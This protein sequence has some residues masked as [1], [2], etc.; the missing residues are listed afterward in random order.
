MS[1]TAK[2]VLGLQSITMQHLQDIIDNEFSKFDHGLC[3]TDIN[4]KDKQ[5]YRSCEKIAS[6]DVLS[7]LKQNNDMQATYVYLRLLKQIISAY[8]GKTTRIT[9]RL[10]SA[11]IIVFTC[12]LWRAWIKYKTFVSSNHNK[13]TNKKQ[14]N[15]D[16]YF[17][18]TPVYYSIEINAHNLLYLILLVKQQQLP[19]HVLNIYLFSSQACESTFRDT[20]S[21]SGTYS[22]IVNFTVSDFLRRAEK[23]SVLQQIKCYGETNTTDRLFFPIHH[24]HK[25]KDDLTT[26]QNINDIDQL[27]I[28]H[29]VFNAYEAAKELVENL[30]I[31]RLLKEHNTYE[32]NDLS[33]YI[34]NDLK[35][36][37]RMND[38]STFDSSSESESD[39]KNYS[40]SEVDN[41]NSISR[42]SYDDDNEDE[43]FTTKKEFS[44]TRLFDSINQDLKDSYFK[45]ELNNVVKYM[46]KQTACWF[47]TEKNNHLS[48]DRLKRVMETNRQG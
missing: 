27:N 16:K 31:S 14:N 2:L 26:Y 3:Q 32:L 40:S 6:E 1:S 4:P 25:Q 33:R 17:L 21:L 22:T 44:G 47:L 8:I 12:R 13:K 10:L 48:S 28:E 11:W 45:I 37:S 9:D 23:L 41:T 46:H 18:T 36:T 42:T 20:R 7:I 30:K 39:S 15:K 29:V 35:S 43:L 24:K 34:Y 19:K 5:N 38:N